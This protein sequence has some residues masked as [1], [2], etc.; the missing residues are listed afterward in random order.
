MLY[1]P[2]WEVQGPDVFSLESFADWLARQP[3]HAAYRFVEPNNCA[4]AQYLRAQGI[5]NNSLS[6]DRLR[7]LRWIDVV[8]TGGTHDTFGHAA[9]R[10]RLISR[11]GWQLSI[12]RFF[13]VAGLI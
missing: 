12:A 8:S 6:C 11:G 13:G 3:K 10:A 7:E 9:R 5:E 2:R 1:D 4:A